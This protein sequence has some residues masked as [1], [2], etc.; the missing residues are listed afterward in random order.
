MAKIISFDEDARRGLERG[1]N[2]RVVGQDG[3]VLLVDALPAD[4][5]GPAARLGPVI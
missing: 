1:M 4:L 3:L 2:V 5:P